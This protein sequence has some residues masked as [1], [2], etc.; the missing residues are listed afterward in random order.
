MIIVRTI[1]ERAI[2][3]RFNRYCMCIF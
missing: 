2:N 3:D 1:V